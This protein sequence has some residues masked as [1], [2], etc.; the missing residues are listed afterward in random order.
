MSSF[1]GMLGVTPMES[2][3]QFAVWAPNASAVSLIGEFNNWDEQACPMESAEGGLWWCHSEAAQNGQEY[4]FAITTAD[5]TVLQ[6]NVNIHIGPLR[7]PQGTPPRC[8]VGGTDGGHI[9]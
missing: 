7:T 4:K 2:G 5:G 3:F 9:C 8:A 6:K 1:N